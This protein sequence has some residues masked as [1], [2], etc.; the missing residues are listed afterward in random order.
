MFY[1]ELKIV[2]QGLKLGDTKERNRKT[3][4][5]SSAMKKKENE[6]LF[7]FNSKAYVKERQNLYAKV[8]N[9]FELLEEASNEEKLC[10]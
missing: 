6:A 8:K 3:D 5:V 1:S 9:D 4:C 2:R 10:S 7:F